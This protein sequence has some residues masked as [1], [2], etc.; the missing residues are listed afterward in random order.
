MIYQLA[1]AAAVISIIACNGSGNITAE[2]D[3]VFIRK[4]RNDSSHYEMGIDPKDSNNYVIRDYN[5]EKLIS[6]G[7]YQQRQPAGYFMS[8]IGAGVKLQF[9]KLPGNTDA[10]YH[11]LDT[12]GNPVSVMVY[13]RHSR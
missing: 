6:T 10:T 3:Y 7:H 5:G 11:F 8:D 12:D 9:Y 1:A 13:R 4:K 2:K